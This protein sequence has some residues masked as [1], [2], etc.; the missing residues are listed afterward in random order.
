M[1]YEESNYVIEKCVNRFKNLIYSDSNVDLNYFKNHGEIL[2][3]SRGTSTLGWC[4]STQKPVIFINYNNHFQVT[5]EF[6]EDAKQSIF[7]FEYNSKHF[8]SKINE[9]LEKS[10]EEINSEW[11][12]MKK[13]E[14]FMEKIFFYRFIRNYIKGWEKS[15]INRRLF[16]KLYFFHNC[17]NTNNS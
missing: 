2:I 13:K 1:K 7:Y 10:S 16:I 8:K 14:I 4:L 3:T 17:R 6:T 12:K 15:F 9:L 5:K 11:I